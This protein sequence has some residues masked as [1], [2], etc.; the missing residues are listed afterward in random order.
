MQAEL[1][2]T[3]TELLMGEIVNTHAQY[4]GRELAALGIEITL[5]TTVGDQWDRMAAVLQGALERADLIIITGGLGPTTD[6]LTRDTVARVLGLPLVLDPPSLEH[7]RRFMARRGTVMPENMIRQA[8]F[9]A[10]AKILPNQVG[11]APG[12]LLEYRDRVL[13][14]LPGP[15]DEL[16]PMFARSVRPYLAGRARGGMVTRT[17]LLKVTGIGESAVQQLIGDLG[18]QGNPGIAYVAKPGEVHVRISAKAPGGALAEQMVADLLARVRERLSAYVFGMDDD[19][20]EEVVGRLL[21]Q[22]GLTVAT[23]ESCTGGL[24]ASRLT[25]VPGSSG[26]FLGSVV[27]YHNRIK[28]RVLGVPA[29]VLKE[30]GAVSRETAVAM[31]EGIRRLTGADLGLSV[32][33]IAGPDGGTPEKP[34]G[35]TYIALA[36]PEGTSCREFHFPGRRHGVRQG[37]VNSGLNMIRLYLVDRQMAVD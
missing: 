32:T 13:V 31:A 25:S 8:Y 26:Y 22:R 28:E 6:D 27:A 17:R 29:G 5:H 33:G 30:H 24:V 35:L 16:R 3:G 15:P 21:T 2:F 9:P 7:I 12:A 34:V 37:A 11:T 36:T 23:A 14:L 1:I 10:G 19:V 4:I 18:G 20:L